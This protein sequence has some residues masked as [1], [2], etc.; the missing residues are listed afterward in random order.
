M[1]SYFSVISVSLWFNPLF[2]VAPARANTIEALAPQTSKSG[3]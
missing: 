3:G 1:F 2:D